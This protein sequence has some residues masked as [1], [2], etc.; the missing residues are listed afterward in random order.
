MKKPQKPKPWR[1]ILDKA[2]EEA[3]KLLEDGE[4]EAFITKSNRSY[5]H[6]D[7]LRYRE[8]PKKANSELVWVMM[9]VMR[10]GKQRLLKF[11]G[12]QFRYSLQDEVSQKLHILDIS[13]GGSLESGSK[14]IDLKGMDRYIINSLME[15]AIASSQ[16]EGA[17]TTRKVAKKMLRENKKPRN[18]SEQMIVN[19]YTTMRKISELKD[20]KMTIDL[21]LDLHRSITEDTLKDKMDEGR[22][23][24]SNE[25]VVMDDEKGVIYHTPPNHQKLKDL[26]EEF[27]EFASEDSKEFI[28]PIIKAI[29]L[30]FLIGYIHPFNDGNGRTAR[31][32]FYWYVLTRDYWLFEFMPISRIILKSKTQ[33]GMAYLYTETD[34]N[35]LTYFINYNLDSI[36]K[37]LEDMKAY[38]TR[39]Q[40]EQTESLKLID[41]AKDIN[42][43]QADILKTFM[44]RPDEHVT[45]N[46]IETMYN[47]AYQTARTDLLN[48]AKLGYLEKIPYK[49]KFIFT[50]KKQNAPKKQT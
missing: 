2:G 50:L 13:A 15:E 5:L 1:E 24:D 16:L 39:K 44:K 18:Y 26:M 23:R 6:W 38:L 49:N 34:D 46:E 3:V 8:I 30:H 42:L 4:I 14:F 27:C 22:F 33:Y 9:K 20:T 28:H 25:V 21:L 10:Q 19:G 37:A 47:V 7:E 48:L 29:M 11:G 43:R 17:A 32:I 45:I 35:D 40:N 41:S 36:G 31:A 12:M